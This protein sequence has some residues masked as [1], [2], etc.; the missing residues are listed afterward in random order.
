MPFMRYASASVVDPRVSPTS[1]GNIR[2]A[3]R[4]V[5]R[6][7]TPVQPSENLI[8]RASMLLGR[9]FDPKNFLLTHATLLASVDVYAPPGIKT[10]SII[11]DGFKVNRR[12]SDFRVKPVC[13]KF[14]NNNLDGWSRGV[15]R[16]AYQTWIGGHNFVE[17]VQVEDLSKGRII[18]AVARDIGDSLYV[19]ILLATDRR[20]AD[21][22]TAIENGH[23]GTLSMGCTVDGTVC[24]K[25]GNWAADETEMCPCI[26]YAKG[27]TFYDDD[28]MKHRIA[29]L[30]GHETLEPTGGVKGIEASW[31]G[32]P[33]FT[34]AVLRNIVIPTQ[35]VLARAATILNQV[36]PE[37]D[38]N[39]Q[40][41]VARI[42]Y[43]PS[44]DDTRLV[45]RTAFESR[46]PRTVIGLND[47]FLAGWSQD[48]G[49]GEP[50]QQSQ[51]PK[52]DAAPA[53]AAPGKDD[54]TPGNGDHLKDIEDSIY[55]KVL[56]RVQER[57]KTDVSNTSGPDSSSSTNETLN[58][59]ASKRI[60]K[61]GLEAI[62][63]TASSEVA[64][65]DS[66]ATFNSS[67]GVKLPTELYRAALNIGCHTEYKDAKAFKAACASAMGRTPTASETRTLLHLSNLLTR[68][69]D[70]GGIP[71]HQP[72]GE[73]P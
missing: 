34:G 52:Q 72:Q 73:T 1:W 29:E 33:A 22:V 25:C 19:D 37:W 57:L 43:P 15:L 2:L 7:A 21:L 30:C 66:L 51:E 63:R 71:G 70:F 68:R 49:A 48:T 46:Y 16:K 69:M 65:I 59:L 62:L 58:K 20:H 24:T 11:E 14:L 55:E 31:V 23:M 38:A 50:V 64:L 26:K 44:E 42:G 9:K 53:P 5:A 45:K 35:E 61:A 47:P 36:P 28:G 8:E 18:D 60:Y 67:V 41:K 17:H 56:D 27:N 39:A 3:S 12:Y 32:T 4:G 40:Q 10:G 13:D 54:A 6:A